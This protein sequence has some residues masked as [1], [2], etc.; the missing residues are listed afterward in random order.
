[1]HFFP[2]GRDV[3]TGTFTRFSGIH[4]NATVLSAVIDEFFL[5][6]KIVKCVNHT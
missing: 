6:E 3:G 1:M 4:E 5:I 2:C